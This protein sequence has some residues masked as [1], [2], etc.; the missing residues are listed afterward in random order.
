MVSERSPRVEGLTQN[1]L[2][3]RWAWTLARGRAARTSGD[4]PSD[5]PKRYSHVG[6]RNQH[7]VEGSQARRDAREASRSRTNLLVDGPPKSVFVQYREAIPG[8]AVA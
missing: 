6:R 3:P 2:Q 5:S 7:G 4:R 1:R 8:A